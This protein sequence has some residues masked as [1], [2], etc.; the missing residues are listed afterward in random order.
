MS[1]SIA[2]KHAL[3]NAEETKNRREKLTLKIKG[4]KQRQQDLEKRNEPT[5]KISHRS[6][7]A[8]F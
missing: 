1:A 8:R 6:G 2:T 5:R 3:T 4:C 7:T